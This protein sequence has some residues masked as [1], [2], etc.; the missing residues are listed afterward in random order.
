M[1]MKMLILPVIA[2][3]AIM[4]VGLV[5][6][7]VT[8]VFDQTST[9]V[10]T[11][12]TYIDGTSFNIS[13]TITGHD[14]TTNASVGI[15]TNDVT[16]TT[17]V[18]NSTSGGN[19]TQVNASV[20]TGEFLDTQ[21]ITFTYTLKN[22]SQNQ[23]ATCTGAY[24]ADNDVPDCSFASGFVSNDAYPPTQKWTVN[25]AN[26]S[27]ATLKFGSNTEKTM[28]ESGDSCTFTGDKS[29][30]PQGSYQVLLATTSDGLNATSCSLQSIRIDVGVPL[31]E[32]AAIVASQAPVKKGA[33]QTKNNN[34]VF[35]VII[36]L[37]AYWYIRRK[38]GK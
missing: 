32:I 37:A 38:K 13:A 6:A 4:M 12:S 20:N 21:L 2:L 8:C 27:S 7:E 25:C 16:S 33:T 9:T 3:M 23:V 36:G 14:Q 34:T 5:N 18:F 30:V 26:A 10:G 19:I 29:T 15:L 28:A 31:K 1:R 22:V 35:I 11:R 24:I 17:H